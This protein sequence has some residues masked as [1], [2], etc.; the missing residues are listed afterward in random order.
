M[1]RAVARASAGVDA[2]LGNTG[3]RP[4]WASAPVPW[5]WGRSRSA[6]RAAAAAAAQPSVAGMTLSR[7]WTQKCHP[8]SGSAHP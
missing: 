7:Y 3:G 5:R 8:I 6:R 2:H 4:R 1:P